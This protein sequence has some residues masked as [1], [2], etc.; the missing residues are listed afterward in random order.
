[1]R[2]GCPTPTWC[3]SPPPRPRSPRR[4][5][6]LELYP[7]DLAALARGEDLPGGRASPR[8]RSPAELVRRVLARFPDLYEP[9]RPTPSRHAP[10]CCASLGYEVTRGSD[11][12]L[13]TCGRPPRLSPVARARCGRGPGCARRRPG[14]GRRPG[15][16]A[17]LSRGPSA[18]RLHRTQ[19][20]RPGRGRG[21]PKRSPQW[22]ASPPV[23]VTA[24]FVRMLREIVAEQGR[25]AWETVL[26]ADSPD[27]SPAART[28]FAQL[29]AKD[30]GAAGRAH[31]CRPANGGIVLLHDATPL[32]RYTGGARTAREAGGGG[33]G[34]RGVPVRAVAAVPHGGPAG[35]R[36]SSTG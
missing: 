9:N 18:R 4:R 25:P 5:P 8:A 16:P 2:C 36:R 28:G 17:R 32:A 30:L 13:L 7:R 3:C 35:L 31:P 26:A 23:N 19:D 24:E 20:A 34:R 15:T 1:M 22:T 6:R 12:R 11:G 14:H 21:S 29:V 33:A 10:T 27:A